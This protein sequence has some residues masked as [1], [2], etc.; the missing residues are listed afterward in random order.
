MFDGFTGVALEAMNRARGIAIEGG[1]GSFEDLHVLL[2]ILRTEGALAPRV[3]LGCGQDPAE[4]AVRVAERARHLQHATANPQH[5]RMTQGA[6]E[7]GRLAR[8]EAAAMGHAAVGTHHLLLGILAS[9][10]ELSHL[11]QAG[12]L[13]RAEARAVAARLHAEPGHAEH[14]EAHA[15]HA[16][17]TAEHARLARRAA[18]QTDWNSPFEVRDRH[19]FA[20][21]VEVPVVHSELLAGNP[22]GEPHLR[23]FPVYLPPGYDSGR[24]FPVVFLLASFTGRWPD[25]LETHP[26]RRGVIA[27]L[28]EQ[29][30]RG[31]C[32]PVI[33]AMPDGWTALGGSQYVD[34]TW[35][36][37]F[38][39]YLARE[40]VPLLD[41]RYPTL[42]G[43]RALV[44]KSSGG[45]GA[46]WLG[47]RHPES[48]PVVAALSADCDFEACFGPELYACLRGL[49][50]HG[51]DPARFLADFRAKPSFDG[52]RHAVLNVLAMAS[53]YSP[54]PSAPLGFDL[55]MDLATGERRPEIWRRWLEFDPL[56]AC[57]R[58]SA[59]LR[60]LEFLHLEC[61]LRDEFHLQWGLRKLVLR[62]RQHGVGFEHEEHEGG[63]RG[64]SERYRTVLPRVARAL[65]AR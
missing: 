49:L 1:S 22:A 16:P 55:P 51:G 2:G 7:A 59:G 40:L 13:Q 11:L 33:V 44:G 27:V 20:G 54:N 58:H 47:M 57:E 25:F 26:W 17:Q 48:F 28:D 39:S 29:I 45:F 35:N 56:H 41:E 5:L 24:R 37:P 52:D 19:A 38:E 36:G 3:L 63:H 30:A 23:E 18:P 32:E 10:S 34:S 21:R 65:Y 62:L 14:T 6:V 8:E 46:L 50:P 61:G 31:E 60:A 42:P 43:R 4:V 9:D 12:G 53:C 64:L 15:L